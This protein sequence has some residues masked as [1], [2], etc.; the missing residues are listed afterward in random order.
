[1]EFWVCTFYIILFCF[2]IYKANFFKL[3]GISRFIMCG[4]FLFKIVIGFVLFNIYSNVETN[5]NL[6]DIFRY[7]DDGSIIYHSLFKHPEDFFKLIFRFNCDT[8][9]FYETY[10]N[11]FNVYDNQFLF[12]FLREYIFIT[13]IIAILSIFTMGYYFPVMIIFIFISFL[14]I[15]AFVKLFKNINPQ[16]TLYYLLAFCLTPSLALWS[17]GLLKETFLIFAIGF[18]LLYFQKFSKKTPYYTLIYPVLLLLILLFN[19]LYIFC[20]I[21]ILLP[22][23]IICKQKSLSKTICYYCISL[24]IIIPLILWSVNW[25]FDQ[26]IFEFL[27]F[28]RQD[29]IALAEISNAGSKIPMKDIQPDFINFVKDIPIALYHSIFL[30]LPD[31]RDISLI[32]FNGLENIFLI[33]CCVCPFIAFQKPNTSTYSLLIFAFF[34]ILCNILLIGWTTPVIGAIVRYRSL[35]IPFYLGSIITLTDFNCLENKIKTLF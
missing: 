13:N 29:F 15:I 8:P 21:L 9:Y 14:G 18:L 31:Y 23:Y 17:S 32:F 16:K 19:R 6:C 27:Y 34:F 10:Y 12:S 28:K 26:D 1:M 30:P 35:L 25:I 2:I 5:R 24:M 33:S 11:Q 7:F 20:I 22:A 4:L 3:E